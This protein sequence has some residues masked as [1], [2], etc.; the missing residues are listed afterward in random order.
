M[1]PTEQLSTW[2]RAPIDGWLVECE[3]ATVGGRTF[4]AEIRIGPDLGPNARQRDVIDKASE[5][6]GLTARL[7]KRVTLTGH[8]AQAMSEF[9]NI[10]EDDDLLVYLRDEL[11]P[12]ESERQGRPREARMKALAFVAAAYAQAYAV[13]DDDATAHNRSLNVIVAKRLGLKPEQVRDRVSAA[14]EAGLLEP[15][16][17]GR[18]R[19]SGQLT[20]RAKEILLSKEANQ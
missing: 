18:G 20:K 7:L 14:R 4:I 12:S 15:R 5:L 11:L 10:P 19:A 6:G 3:V 16:S 9:R 1:E 17:P 2:T 13:M 8:Y